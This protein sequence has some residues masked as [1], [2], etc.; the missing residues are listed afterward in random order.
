[1]GSPAGRGRRTRRPECG[2]PLGIV[3]DAGRTPLESLCYPSAPSPGNIVPGVVF[4][5]YVTTIESFQK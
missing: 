4:E 3:G 2:R 5:V 1:M